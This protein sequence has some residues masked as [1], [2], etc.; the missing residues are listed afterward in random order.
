VAPTGNQD[1]GPQRSRRA[2]RL[3][4]ASVALI[5][6]LAACGQ[7]GPLYLPDSRPGKKLAPPTPGG[8]T[9]PATPRAPVAPDS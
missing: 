8:A 6:L 5:A 9:R 1:G 3:I 7:R 4:A 2:A